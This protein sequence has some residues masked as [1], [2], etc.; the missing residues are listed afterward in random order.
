MNCFEG[1]RGH[2]YP[3]GVLDYNN[4]RKRCTRNTMFYPPK[5]TFDQSKSLEKWVRGMIEWSTR[6]EQ[7][8]SW[9]LPQILMPK[10]AIHYRLATLCLEYANCPI[11]LTTFVQRIPSKWKECANVRL[12]GRYEHKGH[13]Y[14]NIKRCFT[15]T[16]TNIIDVHAKFALEWQPLIGFDTLTWAPNTTKTWPLPAFTFF[17]L[18]HSNHLQIAWLMCRWVDVHVGLFC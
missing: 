1:K 13:F 17:F 5:K 2:E 16:K 18:P 12:N 4:L 6:W 10:Y 15:F 8:N 11:F 9:A 7:L 14:M 3:F